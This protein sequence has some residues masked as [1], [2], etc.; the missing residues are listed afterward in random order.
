MGIRVIDG[1]ER[2]I[3]YIMYNGKEV[4]SIYSGP[5]KVYERPSGKVYLNKGAYECVGNY[6][7]LSYIGSS[8]VVLAE[9]KVNDLLQGS[10]EFGG[11]YEGVSVNVDNLSRIEVR[12]S[13]TSGTAPNCNIFVGY[14][15]KTGVITGTGIQFR[16]VV[17]E[18][19]PLILNVKWN[20]EEYNY[21]IEFHPDN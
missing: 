19:T 3:R 18:A 7:V 15:G 20:L 14:K 13:D 10:A 1:Y 8:S 21:V 4:K 2:A 11:T 6:K 5:D 16:G 17:N 12:Y 9:G